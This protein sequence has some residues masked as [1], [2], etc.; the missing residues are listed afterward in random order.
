ML[1]PA[2]A[3]LPA[4]LPCGRFQ[5]A[6][7]HQPGDRVINKAAKV[8][9][10]DHRADLVAGSNPASECTSRP[11]RK[12][13]PPPLLFVTSVGGKVARQ[14]CNEVLNLWAVVCILLL[15][16]AVK[17][18]DCLVFRLHLPLVC[19]LRVQVI[20]VCISQVGNQ[21]EKKRRK[22]L[23]MFYICTHTH[24]CVHVY[25]IH[26]VCI[27]CKNL[28]VMYNIYIDSYITIYYKT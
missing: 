25:I 6:T 2:A 5:V 9:G 14:F 11:S 16:C 1:S 4:C 24:T 13:S 21:V 28:F 8:V 17:A 26:H 27:Y 23:Q 22:Y 12:R 3:C 10:K 18:E 15:D 7:H 20:A 19:Y